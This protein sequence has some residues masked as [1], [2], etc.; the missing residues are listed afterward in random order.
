MAV[1]HAMARCAWVLL[2]SSVLLY[3]T[4]MVLTSRTLVYLLGDAQQVTLT[5]RPPHTTSPAL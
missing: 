2:P 3:G 5:L 4:S 1:P